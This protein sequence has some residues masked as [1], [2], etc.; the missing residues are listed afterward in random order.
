[1][2][3]IN[4]TLIIITF[5]LATLHFYWAFGGKIALLNTL[6]EHNGKKL[7]MPSKVATISVAFALLFICLFAVQLYKFNLFIDLETIHYLIMANLI[8]TVFLIRAIGD[9]KYLGFFKKIKESK[10]A[11]YDSK[12][13]SPLCLYIS[14]SFF[15]LST[16]HL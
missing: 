3:I 14:F 15:Y 5:A 10:F 13:Y 1:M 7:F 8:G 2:Q 11:I 9:F 12:Y 4:L 6:P 16:K